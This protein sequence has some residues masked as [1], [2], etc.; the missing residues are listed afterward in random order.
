MYV[1]LHH[2]QLA[3]PPGEESA[4]R[5]F[6]A[7]VLGLDEIVKPPALAGRGGAW[8][9]SGLL[10]LHLGVQVPFQPATKG[11]PGILVTD[12]DDVIGRLRAA[13]R[14]VVPDQD[15]PGF[16]RVYTA[17]VFGNRL[18]FLQSCSITYP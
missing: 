4:A 10:E 14:E 17:D 6:Y 2:M 15:F 1:G 3:M 12:L 8:F 11:H 9:R 13:D 18:E 7:G 16:R 5:D